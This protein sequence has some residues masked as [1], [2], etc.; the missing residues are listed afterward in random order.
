MQGNSRNKQLSFVE[1]AHVPR[2]PRYLFYTPGLSLEDAVPPSDLHLDE[3]F[4]KL[5]DRDKSR[6]GA[7]AFLKQIKKWSTRGNNFC[8]ANLSDA[9]NSQ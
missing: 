2:R 5:E 3:D 4:D 8:V 9:L 6:K 7:G 1:C